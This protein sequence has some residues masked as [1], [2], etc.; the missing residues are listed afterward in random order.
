M[1][2]HDG[3]HAIENDGMVKNSF[4]KKQLD[5]MVISGLVAVLNLRI[6]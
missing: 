3:N 6:Y 5:G 4:F 1:Q 2:Q